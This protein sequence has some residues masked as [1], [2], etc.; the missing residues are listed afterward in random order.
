MK[1]TRLFVLELSRVLWLALV[2]YS[3]VLG[4]HFRDN[5]CLGLALRTPSANAA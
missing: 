2:D 5:V 3:G 1:V 4:V